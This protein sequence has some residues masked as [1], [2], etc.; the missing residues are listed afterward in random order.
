M[1]PADDKRKA[2]RET[3]DILN[4]ISTL[5][6]RDFVDFVR[7]FQLRANQDTEHTT[8]PPHSLVLRLTY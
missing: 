3:I 2:A 5:L 8:G 6:V 4:E 1:P 7:T